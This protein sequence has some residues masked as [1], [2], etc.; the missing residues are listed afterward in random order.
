MELTFR[1][2]QQLPASYDGQVNLELSAGTRFQ[3]R[4]NETGDIVYELNEVVPANKAWIVGISLSIYE[5][6]V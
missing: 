5:T 1:E 3:I 6:D 4:D 2:A